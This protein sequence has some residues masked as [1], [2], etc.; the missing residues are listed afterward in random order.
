MRIQHEN[1]VIESNIPIAH[2]L[3][4]DMDHRLNKHGTLSMNVMIKSDKQHVFLRASY[5]GQ[6]IQFSSAFDAEEELIF[7]GKINNVTYKQKDGVTTASIEAISYSIELDEDKKQQSFQDTG[8]S[9]RA[10]L[11]LITSE[12]NARFNWQVESDRSLGKPFIQYDETDF[13]FT[14]RLASYFAK[15]IHVSLCTGRADFYFGV[16]TGISQNIDEATILEQGVSEVYYE[17]GGYRNNVP[18]EQY[19]WLFAI[20]S[21]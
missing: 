11:D 14:K 10:L 15:P 19:Y 3:T 12:N 9:F 5:L 4:L 8:M 13:E 16:R 18:R 1:V 6:N 20:L 17:N 21:G 7:S 2:I